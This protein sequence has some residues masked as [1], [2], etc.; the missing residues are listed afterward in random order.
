MPATIASAHTQ[1]PVSRVIVAALAGK[2]QYY[3]WFE[4]VGFNLIMIVF[5]SRQRGA[6]ARFFAGT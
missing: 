4:I 1:P 3:F 6:Y 2:P 5:I